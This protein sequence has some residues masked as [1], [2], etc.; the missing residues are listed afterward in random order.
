MNILLLFLHIMCAFF[1]TLIVES[2]MKWW[3]PLFSLFLYVFLHPLC[4]YRHFWFNAN[5]LYS[6]HAT[7]TVSLTL[8]FPRDEGDS[9][10]EPIIFINWLLSFHIE[11]KIK[12]RTECVETR[13]EQKDPNTIFLVKWKIKPIKSVRCLW[14][15]YNGINAFILSK[16]NYIYR[17]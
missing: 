17:R 11:S 12:K 9:N 1:S 5:F 2:I 13:G 8:L 14:Y 16:Q 6:F 3:N 15:A 7:T 4:A 10:E